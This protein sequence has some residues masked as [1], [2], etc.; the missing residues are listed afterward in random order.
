M[1]G[2]AKKFVERYCEL[3]N[4]TT[5]QLYKVSTPCIDDHHFK[6]EESNSVGELSK[7]C[8]QIVLKCLYL[9]RIGRPE[10]LWSANKLAQS[11]T[12][13]TKACDRRL[14]R[15]ISYI[16]II[17]VNTKQFCHVGNTAKLCRLGLFQDSDFAGD[18]E[19]SKIFFRWKIVRF[20]K[21][22]VL[23]QS[24]GCVRNKLQNQKSYPWT[25]D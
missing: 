11:I 2:H 18:L 6:E 17:H 3:A 14:S 12:I 15:L 5:Q 20:W 21:P 13:W 8:S 19:D 25:Q 22:Y 4:E 16:F 7:V 1:E 10:I 9:A 23:F 24:V